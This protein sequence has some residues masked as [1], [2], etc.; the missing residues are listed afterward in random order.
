MKKPRK[1]RIDKEVLILT[2]ININL[3]DE[4]MAVLSKQ[5]GQFYVTPDQL[6]EML[7]KRDIDQQNFEFSS[8]SQPRRAK[9]Q[10]SPVALNDEAVPIFEA[11]KVWRAKEAREKK[12]SAN[13][14]IATNATLEH[15]ANA[16][17]TNKQALLR[18][19][20]VGPHTVDLYGDAML[21]VLA[22]VTD[23]KNEN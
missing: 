15:I 6:A 14:L 3:S 21:K 7:L 13:F 12:I 10:Q 22:D 16:R 11:L 18:V 1:L 4:Q 20:G 8:S 5:A 19:H 23:E 2:S 17:P 9:R